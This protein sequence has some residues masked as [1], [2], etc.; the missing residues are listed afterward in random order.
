MPKM[1]LTKAPTVNLIQDV[2]AKATFVI[3]P[4]SK[5]RV[6]RVGMSACIG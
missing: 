4:D 3:D 5:W 1:S 2:A 6:R